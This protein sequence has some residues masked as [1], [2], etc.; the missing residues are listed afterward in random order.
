MQELVA[1]IKS[2]RVPIICIANDAGSPKMKTLKGY[3]ESITW[4]RVPAAQISPRIMEICRKEGLAIDRQSVEKIAESTHGDIRQILNFL[5][6]WRKSSSSI[7]FD[8]VKQNIDTSGKDFDLGA[9]DV[10][11]DLF[12][13]VP[14]TLP[15]QPNDWIGDRQNKYFVDKDIIPLFVADNYLHAKPHIQALMQLKSNDKLKRQMQAQPDGQRQL[16]DIL[17]L[18]VISDAADSISAGDLL[19][20]A[21]FSEQDYSLMPPRAFLSTVYPAYLMRGG[22]S[23]RLNFPALLGKTSTRNKNLRISREFKT[24]L[25][26]DIHAD[27]K[28]M[29]MY[30]MPQLRVE[31]LNALRDDLV[32]Y[33]THTTQPPR[34]RAT[35]AVF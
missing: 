2:T 11:P 29:A 21:M 14:P 3:T 30:I 9:F 34:L 17:S 12:K 13:P 5:Q 24:A 22:L 25:S 31:L 20:D 35:A 7:G 28:E 10:V 27:S 18:E 19:G 23:D 6:M 8:Q 15:G 26:V 16:S 32:S 1:L 4:R 33:T